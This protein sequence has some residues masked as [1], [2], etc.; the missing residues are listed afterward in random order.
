MAQKRRN[1]PPQVISGPPDILDE[2][3]QETILADL[4]T[5]GAHSDRWMRGTLSLIIG[6]VCLAAMWRLV[7]TFNDPLAGLIF[8]TNVSVQLEGSE[9]VFS[10]A[11]QC[12]ALMRGIAVVS[13]WATGAVTETVVKATGCSSATIV[14]FV[15]SRIAF[16]A[17][18]PKFMLWI[19]GSGAALFALAWYIDYDLR[20]MSDEI[21]DLNKLRY[22][23]KSI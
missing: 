3:E 17:A 9:L 16:D 8:Q 11:C 13:G 10:H 18:L 20:R 1:A 15:G 21:E 12:V 5:A 23:H 2:D 22:A 19:P 14:I 7:V 4:R 6:A